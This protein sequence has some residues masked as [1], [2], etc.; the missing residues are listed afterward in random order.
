MAAMM[1]LRS[2]PTVQPGGLVVFPALAIMAWGGLLY[3]VKEKLP[4]SRRARLRSEST[5]P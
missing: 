4:W 1:V 2:D 3:L 5:S